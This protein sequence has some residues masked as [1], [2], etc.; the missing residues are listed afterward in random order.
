MSY[1]LMNMFLA[2]QH[3]CIC[4]APVKLCLRY[5]NMIALVVRCGV[6]IPDAVCAVR[7]YESFWGVRRYE[8][9]LWCATMLV[10]FIWHAIIFDF[11]ECIIYHGALFLLDKV[12]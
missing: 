10:L 3:I 7:Q 5:A 1:L 6:L 12:A 4:G 8:L 9:F 11:V 2:R